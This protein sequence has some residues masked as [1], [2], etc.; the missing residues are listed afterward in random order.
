MASRFMGP[1]R[2]AIQRREIILAGMDQE[3]VCEQCLRTSTHNACFSPPYNTSHHRSPDCTHYS[4]ERHHDHSVDPIA[5]ILVMASPLHL[6]TLPR[7]LRNQIYS[8]LTHES[9]YTLD[10]KWADQQSMFHTFRLIINFRNAPFPNVLRAHSGLCNEY[11]GAP[12]FSSLSVRVVVYAS[13]DPEW[14]DLC[15]HETHLQN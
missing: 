13:H 8:Y 1:A 14:N 7:E 9:Q 15:L 2:M 4:K 12:C 3:A 11:L 10:H 6:L 5:T